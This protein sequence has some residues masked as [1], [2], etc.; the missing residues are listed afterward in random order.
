MNNVTS[1]MNKQKSSSEIGSNI[2]KYFFHLQLFV[3]FKYLWGINQII[4]LTPI[5][6]GVGTFFSGG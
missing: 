4:F 6:I 1:D 5:F 3:F 2:S